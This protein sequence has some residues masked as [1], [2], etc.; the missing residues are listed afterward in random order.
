MKILRVM[1]QHRRIFSF[2]YFLL[3]WNVLAT[4]FLPISI[5]SQIDES[6]GVFHG[7]FLKKNFKILNS[8]DQVVTVASFYV[9]GSAGIKRNEM[10][11]NNE[12][13]I[14]YPGGAWQ[15]IVYNVHGTPEFHPNEE[16]IVLV[17]KTAEGLWVHNLSLG[18]YKIERKN[19]RDY[20][21]S[22]VFPNHPRFGRTAFSKFEEILINKFGEILSFKKGDKSISS[23]GKSSENFNTLK[24]STVIKLNQRSIASVIDNNE[25]ENLEE[26]G[27]DNFWPIVILAFLGA[28]STISFKRARKSNKDREI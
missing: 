25:D 27:F 18:V 4:T 20:L 13:K 19:G 14:M 2:F 8:S 11:N 28:F 22:T 17:S 1:I 7:R 12:F 24:N 3:S 26:K 9:L 21:I 16:A 6:Y 10:L 15:G 5:K 23:N